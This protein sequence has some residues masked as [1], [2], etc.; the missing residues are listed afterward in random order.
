MQNERRNLSERLLDFAACN[1]RLAIKLNKTVMGKY[2]VGE[3]D[4]I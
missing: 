2:L 3:G 1:I 4:L